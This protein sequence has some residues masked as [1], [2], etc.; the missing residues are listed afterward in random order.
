[1]TIS[2]FLLSFET[3]YISS[4]Y[5]DDISLLLVTDLDNL[6]EFVQNDLKIFNKTPK[7]ILDAREGITQALTDMEVKDCTE[8]ICYHTEFANAVFNYL[9]TLVLE[10]YN[11]VGENI[12]PYK[13]ADIIPLVDDVMSKHL[14][15]LST[16]DPDRYLMLLSNYSAYLKEVDRSYRIMT[17]N[18]I[19]KQV[20]DEE[21]DDIC[22]LVEATGKM[23]LFD[24]ASIDAMILL[25]R[26]LAKRL[27]IAVEFFSTEDNEYT[28]PTTTALN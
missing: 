26:V 27:A 5:V 23:D 16:A 12:F 28:P 11:N 4:K 18:Y 14:K 8:E 19:L 22:L 10:I 21:N 15:D 20:R 13:V 2:S 24:P 6:L 25:L 1:M 9:N 17:H 3:P 7:Q